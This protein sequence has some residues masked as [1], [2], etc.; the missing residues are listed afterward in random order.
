MTV[1]CP[2]CKTRFPVDH[3]KIPSG[4]VHARCSECDEV[5]FVAEPAALSDTAVDVTPEEVE[6]QDQD[7]SPFE[8]SE[9]AVEYTGFE[10]EPEEIE[11]PA[12]AEESEF[13]QEEAAGAEETAV[14][15]EEWTFEAESSEEDEEDEQTEEPAEEDYVWG[16]EPESPVGEGAEAADSAVEEIEQAVEPEALEEE[17]DEQIQEAAGTGFVWGSEPPSPP[18]EEEEQEQESVAEADEISP[19]A[20]ESDFEAPKP[21]F[22][23]PEPFMG[24]TEPSVEEQETVF[25]APEPESDEG[26]A[27]EA[28]AEEDSP[29]DSGDLEEGEAGEEEDLTPVEDLPSVGDMVFEHEVQSLDERA[30]PIK[31]APRAFGGPEP[32]PDSA[33][34]TFGEAEPTFSMDL[35]DSGTSLEELPET[36][37]ATGDEREGT[38]GEE[39][40]EL[41]E[42]SGGFDDAAWIQGNAPPAMG[43]QAPVGEEETVAE[44]T[45]ESESPP[46][47]TPQFGKR[48]PKEKAQRLARVLV[49]D[50]ILYNPDRHQ[51]ALE[52]GRIKEEFDDEIQ[53]SWN[54]YVE[55][56][57]EDIA[58]DTEFFNQALNEILAK[59][60]RV[61]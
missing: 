20:F 18:T 14:E 35:S 55:Q 5:F 23:E 29:E 21:A 17:E 15:A 33:E 36:E 26:E 47:P 56:V 31:E 39:E 3:R 54:E 12:T 44:T 46:L 10:I 57:G 6:R 37:E 2:A 9:P 40:S 32:T 22:Q 52:A 49:S 16:T 58:N 30:P 43:F 8:V 42:V 24:T 51:R 1:E 61:F 41:E 53:K 60:Q 50:I 27:G 13:S 28:R 19:N 34:P 11:A 48:D 45:P 4:G 25:H 38:G 59:G 7:G